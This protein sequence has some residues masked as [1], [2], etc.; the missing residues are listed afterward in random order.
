VLAG[1]RRI[2]DGTA[3]A[4]GDR[5]GR[6]TPVVLDVTDRSDLA[7]LEQSLPARL[8]AVVANAGI[9][10]EGPIESL[11]ID[12]LRRQLEV[13]V[14]GQVALVQAVLPKLRESRGRIVLI[15]S[16]S[17]RISTP[18]TGAYNA[19]KFALEAIADSL[20]VELRPW[21]IKVV[22]VEPNSTDTEMWSGALER[23]DAMERSLDDTQRGLYSGHL[24]GMRKTTRMIEKRTVPVEN[25]VATVERAL[26]ARRPRARYPVGAMSRAQIAMA[27]AT[28]TP[29]MD[30][31]LARLMRMPRKL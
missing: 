2:E 9:I 18:L 19:S 8:D 17:G 15:S 7:A 20:R 23:I 6:V 21:G 27:A 24:D 3:I 31:A 28:P 14:V 11:S 30:G 12:A 29:V 10:V 5:A 1:V 16:V 25:V 26:T 13:N 4:A 22:L